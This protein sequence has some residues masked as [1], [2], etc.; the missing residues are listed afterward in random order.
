MLLELFL[1]LASFEAD[2][3]DR[4]GHDQRSNCSFASTEHLIFCQT[5]YRFKDKPYLS[6]YDSHTVDISV[7]GMILAVC[8]ADLETILPKIRRFLTVITVT[9]DTV[10]LKQQ[11]IRLT[12]TLK[13]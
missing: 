7:D 3:C 13:P 5:A 9:N 4:T 10:P 1:S 8:K 11:Y 12:P 2:V 6:R